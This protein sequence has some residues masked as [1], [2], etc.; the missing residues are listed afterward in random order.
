MP[1]RS[2]RPA[3]PRPARSRPARSRPVRVALPA[4]TALLLAVAASGCTSDGTGGVGGTP[5]AHGLRDPLFPRAG[6]GGYDVSHYALDL[7]YDPAAHHLKGTAEI[8]ARATQ[9][10]SAFNL[11]LAKLRVESATVEGAAA[12]V[13]QAGTELTLRPERDLRKGETFKA[14]VRYSGAPP[15]ITSANSDKEGWLRSDDRKVSLALGEPTG[16]MA[17][18][19]GNNHPSDKATYDIKVT[20][21]EGQKAISNGELRTPPRTEGG[22]TTFDWQMREP[23]ASYLAMLAVGEFEVWEGQAPA[24]LGDDEEEVV[25]TVPVYAAAETSVAEESEQLRRRIPELMEWCVLNFGPYPYSSVGSVVAREG[26]VSY[27]LESQTKPVYGGTDSLESDQLHELAHQWFGNSVSPKT[28]RD[29]WLNESFATYAEWMWEEDEG[30][31]SAQEQFEAAF[32]DDD[33]WEFPPATPPDESRISGDPVYQRGAMVLHKIRQAVGSESAFLEVVQGWA[34]THRHTNASTA[35]FTSY[36]EKKTHKDLSA[37]WDVWL[38]G[39]A[40]PSAHSG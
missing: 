22:R 11:D 25:R 15:R 12:A 1:S 2:P 31:P 37:V 4:A 21:P 16:S 17:W 39:D 19:P 30:G 33:N 26:D 6:N 14:V 9:D 18:F 36:V 5:G 35:D 7:D 3:R 20:V 38:H 8:T 24:E 34:A 10:L 23:M 32:A 40:K 27:A 29:M 28:W 13:N